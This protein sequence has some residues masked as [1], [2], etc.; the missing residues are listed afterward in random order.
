M[1][2]LTRQ[3]GFAAVCAAIVSGAMAERTQFLAYLVYTAT[4]MGWIYPVIAHW[5]WNEGGWLHTVWVN[6]SLRI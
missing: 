5:V 1:H 6:A 4:I 2:A 3:W